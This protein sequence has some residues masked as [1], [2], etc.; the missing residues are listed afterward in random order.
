M[1]GIRPIDFDDLSP[2]LAEVLRSRYERLGYLGDFFRNMAHQ[3]RA[4][5]AFETFTQACKEALP[6]LVAEACA[7]TAATRLGNDYERNQHERLAVRNGTS[8]EWIAAVERLE[9]DAD[10][11]LLDD[12]VRA[13][14][15]FVLASIDGLATATTSTTTSTAAPTGA[16]AERLDDLVA[17]TDDATAA[18]IAL[19]TARF[20]GHALVS[21]ACRLVPGVPSIFEGGFSG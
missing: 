15:R 20:V 2:D 8:R 19:L 5:I 18:A 10:S 12:E 4:L 11:G 7:L 3:P 17:L 6:I 14:Q 9:P 16:A 21:S 1:S 13:T